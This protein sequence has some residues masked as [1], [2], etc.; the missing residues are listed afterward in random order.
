MDYEDKGPVG[1]PL[2]WA[3]SLPHT[4]EKA[5]CWTRRRTFAQV[6][7]GS[8]I[9]LLP[10]SLVTYTVNYDQQIERRTAKAFLEQYY[11]RV[12]NAKTRNLA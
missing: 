1:Y 6:R 3:N 11:S 12:V 4:K 9:Q 8:N 5:G 10:Y 2:Y 7:R